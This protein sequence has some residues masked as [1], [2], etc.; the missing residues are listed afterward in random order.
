MKARIRRLVK[1]IL[2]TLH[3]DITRN[4]RYD[5]Q[6]LAIMKQLTKAD[7]NCIDIGCHRGDVLR[8]ML[9][10]SP[11]GR[12]FAFEPI[13]D[14]H[15]EL[16][17][18]FSS[19][20]ILVSAAALSNE[21]G[22]ASFNV[23]NNDLGYSGLKK[24]RY[25]I[26]NPDI[27]EVPVDTDRLDDV[28]PSDIKIDF[29]KIDVEGAE[30]PVLRGGV[31]TLKRCK[32]SIVFECGLG[33]SE[34]YGTTPKMVH[35]LLTGECGLKLYTLSDWLN[36]KHELSLEEFTDIFETNREYYFLAHP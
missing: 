6:T 8:M 17:K 13:P 12:H 15:R 11:K 25:D 33:S 18:E 24:R 29:I 36:G 35:D 3:I 34:F 31:Q 2:S 32:P 9:H 28:I 20:N 21:K 26:P 14:L 4:M 23:V 7:S 16:L 1:L 19:D 27:S 22:R 5:R 10:V 30:Y